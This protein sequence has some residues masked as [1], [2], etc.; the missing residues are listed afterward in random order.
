VGVSF[1]SPA[2]NEAWA[3]DPVVGNGVQD[4][5]YQYELWSD[6]NKTLAIYYGSVSSASAFAAG[7]VTRLIGGDGDLL[8]E[9]GTINVSVSPSEVLSDCQQLFGN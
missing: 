8:L 6:T 4:A 3:N 9:Y 7:R 1:D 2:A 5:P